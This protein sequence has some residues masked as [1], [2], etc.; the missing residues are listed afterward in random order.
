MFDDIQKRLSNAFGRLRAPWLLEFDLN[1]F[2]HQID[3]MQKM[4]SVKD[5]MRKI[6]GFRQMAGKHDQ[7]DVDTDVKHIRGI[8]DSMTPSE[9]QNPHSIDRPRRRRI[10][11]GAGVDPADVSSLVKQFDAMA[12]MVKQMAQMTMIDKIKALTG[13]GRARAFSPGAKL[14]AP[15]R[16]TGK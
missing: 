5:L 11:A 1:D 3:Q 7:V 14:M 2:R 13:L 10:A 8:I 9:R 4:G 16:G 12:A 6:P 15:R